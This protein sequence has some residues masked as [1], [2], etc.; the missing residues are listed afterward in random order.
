[1]RSIGGPGGMRFLDENSEED[2][3]LGDFIPQALLQHHENRMVINDDDDSD[4]D[5]DRHMR[6]H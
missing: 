3:N 5:M 1:M 4:E 2:Q 6:D